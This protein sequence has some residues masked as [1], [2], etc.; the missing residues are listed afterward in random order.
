M[1][2]QERV[3]VHIFELSLRAASD[4]DLATARAV[5]GAAGVAVDQISR[6][7]DKRSVTLKVFSEDKVFIEKLRDLY[8]RLALPRVKVVSAELK[9]DDWLTRWKRGWKPAPLTRRLDVV[10]VWH[11]DRYVQKPGRSFILMDTLLSFGTGLHETTRIMAQMIEDRRASIGSLMDIGTGT[12]VLAMVA[13]KHGAR[14]VSAI[15]I[16]D[17]SVQAAR[18]NLKLNGLKAVVKRADVG[19]YRASRRFDCVAA[20]LVTQDL[21]VHGKKLVSLTKPGGLLAVSGI[22]LDN[23]KRLRQAFAELPLT[24]VQVKKGKEWAGVLYRRQK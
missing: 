8:K 24:A 14:D 4:P 6:V 9:P 12:G 23:L 18:S 16:G 5:L 20:N 21:I 1:N 15:D 3:P 22:S 17:L 19:V 2:I 13:L 7:E 10:P 11:Q